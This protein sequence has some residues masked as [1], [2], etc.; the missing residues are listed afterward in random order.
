MMP[1]ENQAVTMVREH[2]EDIPMYLLPPAYTLRSFQPGDEQVWL[3]IQSSA[4]RYNSITPELFTRE[5]GGDQ[6]RLVR[7]QLYLCDTKQV[8]VGT[9]TAWFDKR[10][11]G[12]PYGRV[13]WLAILPEHQGQGLAKPLMTVILQRLKD[14]GHRRAYLTTSA[15]RFVAINLYLQFGFVAWPRSADERIIWRRLLEG[16]NKRNADYNLGIT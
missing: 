4:D 3:E 15:A 1:V 5:F 6:A 16:I 11:R 13:H 10:Y 8:A 9:A 14:L 12:K 2:L 7:R